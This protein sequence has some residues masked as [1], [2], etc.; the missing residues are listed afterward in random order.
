MGF[1]S[2]PTIEPWKPGMGLYCD[3][4][5]GR[6]KHFVCGRPVA[7][8]TEDRTRVVCAAHLASRLIVIQKNSYGAGISN[9]ALKRANEELI[10][11]YWDEHRLLVDKYLAEVSEETLG[12]LP[13]PL[14]EEIRV[15]M[16]EA[17]A[18]NQETALLAT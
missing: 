5:N 7:Q 13:E 8:I 3:N 2:V 10:M 1:R 11:K 15:Q 16:R 18:T 9:E 14:R 12:L 6:Q 17:P 4:S